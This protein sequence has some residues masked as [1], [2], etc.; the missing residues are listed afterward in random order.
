MERNGNER[1]GTERSGTKRNE[2]KQNK[3]SEGSEA[4]RNERNE[5]NGTKRTER[6]EANETKRSERN[7]LKWNGT[8]R[9]ETNRNETKRNGTKRISHLRQTRGHNLCCCICNRKQK[10]TKNTM[11]KTMR[12]KKKTVDLFSKCLDRIQVFAVLNEQN[13]LNSANKNTK[14]IIRRCLQRPFSCG[15]P[16]IFPTYPCCMHL[17]KLNLA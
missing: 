15:R 6:N 7:E 16:L 11:Q 17:P 10:H 9:N 14:K 4:K 12:D 1:N 8:K 13:L 5:T 2:T 3:T